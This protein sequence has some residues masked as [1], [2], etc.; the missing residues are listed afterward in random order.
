[1]AG[2]F[3]LGGEGLTLPAPAKINRFLHVL[4]RD[5]AGYHQLQTVF[6]FCEWGDTLELKPRADA[7]IHLR[8]DLSGVAAADN[9][10]H[11]AAVALRA[12][13]GPEAAGLGADIHLHK[14]IPPGSGLGGGSSDAAT[15]L[16]GLNALWKLG[17]AQTELA[18]IGATL[19]ADVPVFVHGRACF[20]E[21]RGN[22]V[23]DVAADEGPLCLVL[24]PLH[25]STAA[26]FA[27]PR[28]RRDHP[29]IAPAQWPAA[30]AAG[31]ND[32]AA[33]ACALQPA[34]GRIAGEL[35]ALG[36]FRMSGTG[37]AFYARLPSR[38]K[39]RTIRGL[40]EAVAERAVVTSVSN[41]SPL[42]VALHRVPPEQRLAGSDD[43]TGA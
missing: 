34:L 14:L 9:L 43:R 10:A 27:H 41:L 19:G 5:A 42:H 33:A 40:V 35:E 23:L 37:S 26:V 31:V 28:M 8:G 13:A 4:G 38:E 12:A 32:C 11:R 22:P 16:L 17:L 7:Q 29:R 39:I 36:P 21:G 3:A 25:S 15:V 6:Q 20:A 1:M 24:P 18:R 2:G 30:V